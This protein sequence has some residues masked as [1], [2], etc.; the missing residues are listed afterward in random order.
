MW[1]RNIVL[2]VTIIQN[3]GCL[4]CG[5]SFYLK[6]T[7]SFAFSKNEHIFE[8]SVDALLWC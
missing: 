3:L 1:L 8:L 6:K 7:I 4:W 2:L 5:V